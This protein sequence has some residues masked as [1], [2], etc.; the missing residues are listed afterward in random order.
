MSTLRTP[1]RPTKTEIARWLERASNAPGAIGRREFVR[2]VEYAAAES[3]DLARYM[4]VDGERLR[5]WIIET[6]TESHSL[7]S[8]T[9]VNLDDFA[10]KY[11]IRYAKEQAP[12]ANAREPDA[13]TIIL[14]A[15]KQA[16]RLSQQDDDRSFSKLHCLRDIA[17]RLE[18]FRAVRAEA[19]PEPL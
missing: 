12:K 9:Y 14:E 18:P 15:L 16:T 17:V 8:T 19:A 1:G 13:E 5:R 10:E 2:G 4:G 3:K 6:N 11:Q 7:G